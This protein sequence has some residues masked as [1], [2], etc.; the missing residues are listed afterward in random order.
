MKRKPPPQ[1]EWKRIIKEKVNSKQVKKWMK[2]LN[3]KKS[4]K[5]LFGGDL[6]M[7]GKVNDMISY[8]KTPREVMAARIAVKMLIGE[9]P[10]A[11]YQKRIGK[12]KE[13]TCIYCENNYNLKYTD[14]NE[15]IITECKMLEDDKTLKEKIAALMNTISRYGGESCRQKIEKCKM[16]K[17]NFILNCTSFQ[18]KHI[19]ERVKKEDIKFIISESH[20]LLLTLWNKRKNLKRNNGSKESGKPV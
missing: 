18:V 3:E 9:L 8:C 17:T 16:D 7:N 11:E 14:N 19:N 1:R 4:M 10:T 6:K 12:D 13:N 20:Q 2:N 5:N 15:H